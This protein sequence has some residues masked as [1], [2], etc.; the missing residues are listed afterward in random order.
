M[1]KIGLGIIL[2]MGLGLQA[3]TIILPTDLKGVD[4]SVRY[5]SPVVTGATEG[6]D[7]AISAD[8]GGANYLTLIVAYG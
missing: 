1:S 5:V 7:V 2:A 3:G 4:P 6:F 8:I